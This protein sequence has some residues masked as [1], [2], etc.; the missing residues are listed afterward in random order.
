MLVLRI[1]GVLVAIALGLCLL[2]WATT[3]ERRWLIYAW[4]V[5][6]GAL[7]LV[8]LVLLLMFGERIL[9]V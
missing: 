1:G 3:G 6:R 4:N 7:L 9:A 8:V 5:F 2:L